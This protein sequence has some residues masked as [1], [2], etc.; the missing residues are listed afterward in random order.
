M[1]LAQGVDV[2][3]TEAVD[4]LGEAVVGLAHAIKHAARPPAHAA[5]RRELARRC[6]RRP[7]AG[8]GGSPRSAGC[9]S[10]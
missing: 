6:S 2:A 5:P 9:P 4:A 1:Q 3:S 8:S 7:S 10:R